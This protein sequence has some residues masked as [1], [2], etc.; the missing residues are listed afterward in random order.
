MH[1]V[2]L[3]V[4]YIVKEIKIVSW[5]KYFRA[6]GGL[7]ERGTLG[8][9]CFRWWSFKGFTSWN[10]RNKGKMVMDFSIN[11]KWKP[12]SLRFPF[13]S[14][15]F[16]CQNRKQ[17]TRQKERTCGSC[18]RVH[19]PETFRLCWRVKTH[20]QASISGLWNVADPPDDRANRGWVGKN[21]WRGG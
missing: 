20:F 16:T 4:S 17:T 9:L 12:R 10:L 14:L 3:N 11:Y 13:G 21:D 5:M 18:G 6:L 15:R 1:L 8:L 2:P 19:Q 7:C